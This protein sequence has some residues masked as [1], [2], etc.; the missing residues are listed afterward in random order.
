M[1]RI[2]VLLAD[3]HM[4]VRE[5]LRMLLEITG[6]F[7]VVGEVSNGQ[8]AVDMARELCPDVVVMDLAMPKLNGLEAARRI[9]Q[10]QSTRTPKVLILS[11][12]SDD[13]YLEQMAAIGVQGYLIKQSSADILSKAIREIVKGK[14]FFTPAIGRRLRQF[15]NAQGAP[16][17]NR[18]EQKQ[19]NMCL[20]TREREV[21]QLSAEGRSNK[22]V[23]S[24]LGISI[25]TVEKHRQSI[26]K[27]LNIHDASGLTRYAIS[28][29]IIENRVQNTILK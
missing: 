4:I 22:E 19:T 12:H 3:D 27:K 1:K 15:Q 14:T 6:E 25:K 26:M 13:V 9:L 20:T 18:P 10:E 21:L 16:H 28:A 17:R 7:E 11:A 24:D 2:T 8:M 5:G 23:G 29:G